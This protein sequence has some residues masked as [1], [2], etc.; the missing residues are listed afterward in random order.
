MIQN[1]RLSHLVWRGPRSK[2]W[3][4]ALWTRVSPKNVSCNECPIQQESGICDSLPGPSRWRSDTGY[5]LGSLRWGASGGIVCFVP[6][7]RETPETRK[8][9]RYSR[10][11]EKS[12]RRKGSLS[13]M[14]WD[15][16]KQEGCSWLP[17]LVR[18]FPHW[19]LQSGRQYR[20]KEK[21]L[22]QYRLWIYSLLWETSWRS[23]RDTGS[24]TDLQ[25]LLHSRYSGRNDSTRRWWKPLRRLG[26]EGSWS[27]PIL[28]K[29][30][31]AAVVW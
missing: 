1:K 9:K 30:T 17:W 31:S 27:N 7:F 26:V 28:E 29:W 25:S 22:L 8:K 18:L 13:A 10:T 2:T 14:T 3:T 15:R 16:G 6:L 24:K 11:Q 23:L 20:Q 5:C 12:S 4:K 21:Q 19:L